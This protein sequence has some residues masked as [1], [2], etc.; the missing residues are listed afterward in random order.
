[1]IQERG[2]RGFVLWL[3]AN[4]PDVYRAF[5]R[6]F[7]GELSGL[8]YEMDDLAFWS[9]IGSALSTVA[10]GVNQFVQSG[11]FQSVVQAASPF[12]QTH[13]EKKAFET[14][15]QRA[16][17]NAPPAVTVPVEIPTATGTRTVPMVKSDTLTEWMP[18][19]IAGGVL[20]T[21]LILTLRK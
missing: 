2:M 5:E 6:R 12:I 16:M 7:A 21:L 15:L 3:K 10:S 9:S 11:G 19:L 1:M 4:M 13:I 17:Q 18:W 14:Q 20:F 8:G